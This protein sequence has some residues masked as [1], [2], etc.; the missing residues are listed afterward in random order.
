MSHRPM[1]GHLLM[2]MVRHAHMQIPLGVHHHLGGMVFRGLIMM[3]MRSRR[4]FGMLSRSPAM[5]VALR[6]IP[7]ALSCGSRHEPGRILARGLIMRPIAPTRGG[8]TVGLHRAVAH[9][10][11]LARA[12]PRWT[13]VLN[14]ARGLVRPRRARSAGGWP[15]L[16]RRRCSPLGGWLG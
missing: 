14:H 9:R 8:G 13:A 2:L 1:S 16:T 10:G 15:R 7:M 3:P 4:G 11:K 6:R 12:L 5:A